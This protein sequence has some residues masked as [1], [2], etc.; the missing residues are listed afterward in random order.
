[1]KVLITGGGG[2]IG[3]QLARRLIVRGELT[4]PSGRPERIDEIALFDVGF[5]PEAAA[6]LPAGTQLLKRDMSERDAVFDAVDRDDIA[7][8][9][10]ASMVSGECEQRFDDALHANLDGMRYLLEACRQRASRPRLVFAS[11]A[12]TFGGAALPEVVTDTTKQSPQT[13]YGMTKVIG[14]LLINDY[15]RK[16]FLDGRA[17]RL[18]TIIIRPGKPNAAA[19]S[20]ASGMFREPLNGQP[21][22][23]PVER[24]QAFPVLGYREV[25]DSFIALHEA[26]PDIL[27]EDRAFCL[28]SLTLTVEEG[29]GILKKVAAERGLS[30]GPFIDAP[31]AV[32]QKIVRG[33]PVGTD[34]TR[35]I[36][37]GVPQPSSLEQIISD[38]IADFL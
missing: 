18:P 20:W 38:Y 24:T 11:S 12:A 23:L 21:C 8:F 26:S 7:I 10:L 22:E 2:F 27:D 16:G 37:A 13:T 6:G 9:H 19:S 3:N 36:A 33:W 28:P 29:I 34:G 30:L 17:A 5:S 4:G 25:V 1:M 14:E 31:N 35:A 32:I 15:T